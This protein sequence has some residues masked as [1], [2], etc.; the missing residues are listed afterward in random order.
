MYLLIARL[1]AV[2][3]S[4][5]EILKSNN[6]ILSLLKQISKQQNLEIMDLTALQA[7]VAA[8]TSVDASV[9]TL[10]TQLAAQL[11]AANAANDQPA[12]DAIVASM[13]QNA[14]T[15]GASVTANTPAAPAA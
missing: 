13:Q 11:A 10:L 6:A 9:E 8:E 2:E 4:N 3:K 1:E 14:A 7:A 15:L 5:K 12:I